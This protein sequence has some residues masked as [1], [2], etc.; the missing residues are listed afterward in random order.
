[1]SVQAVYNLIANGHLK[2]IRVP[3]TGRKPM[4]RVSIA[5]VEAL[6]RDS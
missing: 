1:M 6:E 3:G 2:A 5:S 4:V